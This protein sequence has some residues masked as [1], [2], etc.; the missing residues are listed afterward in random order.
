VA[1]LDCG[2]T[3]YPQWRG[4]L[5]AW[6]RK[7]KAPLAFTEFNLEDTLLDLKEVKE[8][9]DQEKLDL[10]LNPQ[11]NPFSSGK[12]SRT[13]DKSGNYKPHSLVYNNKFICVVKMKQ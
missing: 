11:M 9:V 1:A 3:F 7:T 4:A 2:F 12:P 6:S 5:K 13:S 8:A 10:V